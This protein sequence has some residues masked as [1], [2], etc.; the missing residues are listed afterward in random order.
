VLSS[1]LASLS[2][3]KIHNTRIPTRNKALIRNSKTRTE[4]LGSFKRNVQEVSVQ[5]QSPDK[6]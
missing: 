5:Q 6:A 4:K 1:N 3:L 2:D